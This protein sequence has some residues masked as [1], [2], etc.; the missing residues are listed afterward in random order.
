MA[1]LPSHISPCSI[2]YMSQYLSPV[3]FEWVKSL[4]FDETEPLQWEF[5]RGVVH[6]PDQDVNSEWQSWKPGT[7]FTLRVMDEKTAYMQHFI[8]NVDGEWQIIPPERV[9]YNYAEHR[10][11]AQDVADSVL[12]WHPDR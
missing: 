3:M 11:Y 7:D 1:I 5:S 9:N 8:N 4:G 6:N 12:H 10:A 2:A